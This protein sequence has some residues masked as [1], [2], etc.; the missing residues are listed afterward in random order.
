MNF[1]EL[2][3]ILVP[4]DFSEASPPALHAA[5]R[6]AQTFH[7]SIGVLHVNIDPNLVLP[8]PGDLITAPIDV[9][10]I[11]A[12]DAERLDRVAEEVRR[13]GVPC[14][15]AT[16]VGRTHTEIVNHARGIGAQLIVM[17]THG[18]QGIGHALLGSVA[19]KV[20]QHAPCP[21]LVVPLPAAPAHDKSEPEP[22]APAAGAATTTTKKTT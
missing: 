20:V 22:I 17:G 6:L 2:K 10:D 18:R 7:A 8:P 14:T 16:E 1:D 4:T 11:L 5:I 3:L 15:A 13:A 9:T 21:V 19:E 12:D